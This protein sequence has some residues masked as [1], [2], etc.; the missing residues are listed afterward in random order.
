MFGPKSKQL[1][2]QILV[3]TAQEEQHIEKLRKQL[4]ALPQFEPF[5][6]FRRIDRQSK[7]LIN[8]KALC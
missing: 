2:K 6:A 7:G 3:F 4:C 1:L 5:T 8:A